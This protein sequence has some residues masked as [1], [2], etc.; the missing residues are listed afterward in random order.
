[1][2]QSTGLNQGVPEYNKA[3]NSLSGRLGN[4][5]VTALTSAVTE[6]QNVYSQ[7]LSSGGTTPSGSEAQ[8][9]ALLSPNSTPAQINA[10]IQQLQTAAYNKL[11]GQYQQ[12]Q[13]E[14][15]AL[16]SGNSNNTTSSGAISYDW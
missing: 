10:A 6:M 15:S 1:V 4:A 7:L 14:N 12:L 9:L 8:A 3:I 16:Q 2:L 13:T 11:S 5:N